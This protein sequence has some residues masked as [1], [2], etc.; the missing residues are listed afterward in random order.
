L[1]ILVILFKGIGDVLLG[2]IIAKSLKSKFPES[3]ID[4]IT[5]ASCANM[6]EANPDFRSV[7]VKKDYFEANM[8][9]AEGDY[10]EIFRLSPV[11][12]QDAPDPNKT[13]LEWFSERAE[14]DIPKDRS[15][16]IHFSSDD[17]LDVD[18][19]WD[20]LPTDKK[21]VGFSTND[22]SPFLTGSLGLNADIFN[23]LSQKAIE[24]GKIVVQL[25]LPHDKKIT[26]PGVVDLTD[27]ISIKQT[28]DAIKRCSSFGCFES[29]VGCLAIWTKTETYMFNEGNANLIAKMGIDDSEVIR[30]DTTVTKDLSAT[31]LDVIKSQEEELAP[32]S[33]IIP[34]FHLPEMTQNCIDSV[35]KS[36]KVPYEIIL[37]DN[38]STEEISQEYKDKVKYHKSPTNKMFAGGCNWG[39][40][41]AA[42]DNLCFL[43]NDT[44]VSEG[45]DKPNSY[46]LSNKDIGMVG[47]KLLYPD[48]TIQHAGVEVCANSPEGSIFNHRYR[49]APSDYVHANH[50]REYECVTGAVIFIRKSDFNAVNGFSTDYVN[51]HEDNDLCYKLKFDLNKKIMYYPHVRIYH[52][53]T[54]TPRNT[55][56]FKYAENNAKFY[57]KWKDKIFVDLGIWNNVDESE[58]KTGNKIST[59]K[60][61]I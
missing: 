45:W 27:K 14:I 1:N 43:N 38:G 10:D 46:L 22:D 58:R 5:S 23:K 7:I 57:N 12:Q 41:L 35:I 16:E 54:K 26:T 52:L 49:H 37:V 56:N 11:N 32:I 42:Y 36:T 33:I 21:I 24:D 13:L 34:V 44:I 28:A 2:S 3:Q 39:A 18:D 8:H 9:A 30:V 40:E 50:I 47:V 6:L 51:S 25:G 29:L 20:D 59:Y 48:N 17:I 60:T 15:M 55:E 61:L 4:F 19:Y 31:S 53:E